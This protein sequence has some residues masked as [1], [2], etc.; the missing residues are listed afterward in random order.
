MATRLNTEIPDKFGG[1]INDEALARYVNRIEALHNDRADIN[2]AVQAVYEEA[3]QAGFQPP[4]LRQVLKE[5]KLD[6]EVRADQYA[7]LDAYRRALGMLAD[8]PLGEA[9]MRR[10]E[11]T[12]PPTRQKPK[13]TFAEQPVGRRRGRPRKTAGEAINGARAHLGSEF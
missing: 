3:R 2:E 1:A 4:I 7:L 8:T 5:R 12:T 11:T 6:P 9:A 10:A 13:K